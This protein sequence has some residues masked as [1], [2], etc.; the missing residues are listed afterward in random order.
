MELLVF[1]VREKSWTV[2]TFHYDVTNSVQKV[3]Q[4]LLSY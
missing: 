1:E 2:E 3:I 4:I